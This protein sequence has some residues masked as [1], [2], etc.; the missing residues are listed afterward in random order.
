MAGAVLTVRKNIMRVS[1]GL[2]LTALLAAQA[3]SVQV[4]AHTVRSGLD[5]ASADICNAQTLHARTPRVS[6][7]ESSVVSSVSQ[8]P[9]LLFVAVACFTDT[10]RVT[11]RPTSTA[12]SGNSYHTAA[13]IRGPP[14]RS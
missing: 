13:F 14:V 7:G 11:V 1:A 3:G 5:Q 2:I 8:A 12:P 10:I 6:A 4:Q 9:V